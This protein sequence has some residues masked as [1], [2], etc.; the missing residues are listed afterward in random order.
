VTIYHP[1]Q[2]ERRNVKRLQNPVEFAEEALRQ[3]G[4][5]E[6][7]PVEGAGKVFEQGSHATWYHRIVYVTISFTERSARPVGGF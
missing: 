7:L 4:G 3:I 6:G 5:R 1:V 2:F